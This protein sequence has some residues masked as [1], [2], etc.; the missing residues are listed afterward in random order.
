MRAMERMQQESEKWKER[1][2][3]YPSFHSLNPNFSILFY[4]FELFNSSLVTNTG[5]YTYLEISG[6]IYVEEQI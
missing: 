5:I 2:E 1:R 6:E 3:R 4:S